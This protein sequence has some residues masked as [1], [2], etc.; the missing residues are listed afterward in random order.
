MY[1]INDHS[2]SLSRMTL[3]NWMHKG[4]AFTAKI[5]EALKAMA[6]EKDSKF[7]IYLKGKRSIAASP[8]RHVKT[9]R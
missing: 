4:A 8:I 5:V 2:M 7:L 6:M 3:V 1:R 9:E